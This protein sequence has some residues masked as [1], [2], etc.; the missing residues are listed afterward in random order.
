MSDREFTKNILSS[1]IPTLTIIKCDRKKEKDKQQH[2]K[3]SKIVNIFFSSVPS[4]SF[5]CFVV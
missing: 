3:T 5:V 4:T 1:L 2:N